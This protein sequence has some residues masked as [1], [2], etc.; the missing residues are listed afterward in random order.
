MPKIFVS[1]RRENSGGWAYNLARDLNGEF[2]KDNVFF[3][4]NS[5]LGG[6]EFKEIISKRVREAEFVLVIIGPNWDR[7]TDDYGAW[8]LNDPDDL[9]H[10]EIC[11]ACST[12]FAHAI[13]CTK[14]FLNGSKNV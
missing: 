9:V 11:T 8:R 5:L 2:G 14:R 1:Y 6:D 7:V 10:F 13:Y 4:R 12:F 3:D